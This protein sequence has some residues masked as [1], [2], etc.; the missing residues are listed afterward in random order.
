[1][2]P[3]LT[4]LW[5]LVLPVK[6]RQLAKSRLAPPPGLRRSDLAHAFALDTLT[7][8]SQT[9]GGPAV[10]VV[11]NEQSLAAYTRSLGAHVVHDRGDGLNPAVRAGLAAVAPGRVAVLLG[12]LPALRRADLQAGLDACA[13]HASAFLP[14]AQGTGTVLLA[15]QD[16]RLL[17]PCFGPGSAAA[18][19]QFAVRLDLASAR[20]RDDV[21]DDAALRRAQALGVGPF[22]SAV[23]AARVG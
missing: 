1:M 4:A 16:S 20:L 22:T 10:Y 7:V 17:T 14:D 8:A 5:R 3:D 2:Q 23:L 9:V 19:E 18:H 15:A 11:T 6:D 13:E 21:D 12:D